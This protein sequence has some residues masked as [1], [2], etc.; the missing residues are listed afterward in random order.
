[1]D[2]RQHVSAQQKTHS[3]RV[4]HKARLAAA[5][6]DEGEGAVNVLG[7]LRVEGDVGSACTEAASLAECGE[8]TVITSA[9]NTPCR[10]PDD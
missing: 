8:P 4:E 2:E 1:M 10:M 6:A 9:S 3:G 5:S 7:S